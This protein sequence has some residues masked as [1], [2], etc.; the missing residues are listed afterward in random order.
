MC[1]NFDP[2]GRRAAFRGALNAARTRLATARREDGFLLV[3]VMMSAM[4]VALIVMATFNGLDFATKITSEQKHRAEA[5][6]LAAESQE[7]LR[8][9]PA[10]ALDE[11][12]SQS[13]SYERAFGGVKYKIVQKAESV[14]AS[15]KETGCSV[16]QTS[17]STASNFRVTSTVTWTQKEKTKATPVVNSSIVSPP[18]GSGIEVDVVNGTGGPVS[19]V[20]ARAK[21]IP[22]E[23]GSTT[24]IEG[25][26]GASGCVVL[27]GIQATEATV[28]ILEKTG[29]VTPSGAL[30]IKPKTLTIAPNIT[31]HYVVT[32]AEGGAVQAKF[33][34]NKETTWEGKEVTWD[35]FVVANPEKMETAPEYQVGSTFF[36]YESSGEEKYKA[37]TG[38]YGNSGSYTA[39]GSKY[40]HGDLFPFSNA[41]TAYAGDCSANKPATEPVEAKP[42]PIVTSGATTLVELPVAA[43]K[44]AIYTGPDKAEPGSLY[45]S[46]LSSGKENVPE[47]KITN[48]GCTSEATPNNATGLEYVHTQ[49]ETLPGGTKAGM[50]ED[51]FQPA[52]SYSLCLLYSAEKKTYTTTYTDSLSKV[53]EPTIYLGQRPTATIVAE[54]KKE[55]A[56]YKA[57]ES[58]Y[59]TAET[60]YKEDEAK[61]KEKEKAYK[62]HEA[63]KEKYKEAET[64]KK[65]YET[66]KEAWKTAKKEYEHWLAEYNKSSFFGGKKASQKTEYEKY[67]KEYK[68]FEQEYETLE[69]EYK[70]AEKA[71]EEYAKPKAEYESYLAGYVEYKKQYETAKPKYEAAKKAYEKAK[72]EEEEASKAGVTVESKEAC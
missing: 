30:A 44:L 7:L 6:L 31:T 37:L 5:A 56:L 69:T 13:H 65:E 71:Y 68:K 29:F 18:T 62:E 59:K 66:K 23:S 24:Y 49:S 15:G 46:R 54:R 60:K 20:T 72:T 57:E 32:Y 1:T 28:E 63:N 40:P 70:N 25:T 61:Y 36:K 45:A 34:Y 35:T 17:A 41:W 12:V 42:G 64:K 2:T 53:A 50:L 11:L 26:T 22:N 16:T 52:G 4:L 10:S 39:K 33:T 8:S 47:V 55:E 14:A 51:P 38:S 21:F 9:E 27:S 19:G 58:T 43:T 3:E 67:E 48:T